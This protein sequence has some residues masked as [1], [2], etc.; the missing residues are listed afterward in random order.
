[1]ARLSF[2]FLAVLRSFPFGWPFESFLSGLVSCTY[3]LFKCTGLS[4]NILLRWHRSHRSQSVEA[5]FSGLPRL[6]YFDS[7]P[8]PTPC[9]VHPLL[10]S[11]M[12]P[13]AAICIVAFA[14]LSVAV[15]ARVAD[16]ET[17]NSAETCGD[18]W[19]VRQFTGLDCPASTVNV[20]YVILMDSYNK[21][22]CS[23]SSNTSVRTSCSS[24]TKRYTYD[25]Y[26]G[27]STCESS[28]LANTVVYPTGVCLNIDSA[29]SPSSVVYYC[30]FADAPSYT[31]DGHMGLDAPN[32][33]AD[34]SCTLNATSVESGCTDYAYVQQF[35][36]PTCSGPSTFGVASNFGAPILD[37][38][39]LHR[40]ASM[41]TNVQ[42]T[43]SDS[44]V[45]EMV[46]SD[47]CTPSKF[48]YSSAWPINVCIPSEDGTSSQMYGCPGFSA[49][50]NGTIP[51]SPVAAPSSEPETAPSTSTPQSTPVDAPTPS[52]A[53]S[54][55]FNIL[56]SILVVLALVSLL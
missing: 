18:H 45:V 49:S 8:A 32:L 43:C 29:A 6:T 21:S 4:Y 7:P 48:A 35:S 11:E 22:H 5:Y 14:L 36:G 2:P 24:S 53:P 19:L 16:D 37:R 13:I 52:A 15:V 33:P 41:S 55:S 39:Y 3:L 38:C 54:S 28:K 47:G 56:G 42:S 40:G 17:C 27:T 31:T 51:E 46:Y 12:K 44:G 9:A 1:M 23:A 50:P 20:S 10:L 25:F 26:T 34:S 30:A